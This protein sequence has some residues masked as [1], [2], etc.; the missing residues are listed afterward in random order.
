MAVAA[1]Q[2]DVR[3]E[4]LGHYALNPGGAPAHG[5]T[6]SPP[7]GG[8]SLRAMLLSAAVVLVTALGG[9]RVKDRPPA[10]SYGPTSLASSRSCTARWRPPS[11]PHST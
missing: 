8:L 9:R 5:P 11:W 3:L 7:R 2:L 1:G 10:D 4:K 6:T